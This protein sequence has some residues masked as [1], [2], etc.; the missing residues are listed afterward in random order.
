MKKMKTVIIIGGNKG[1]GLSITKK[2]L[3]NN[4]NVIVGGRTKIN[5]KKI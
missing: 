2:Y 4:F 5:L 3:N 1:I